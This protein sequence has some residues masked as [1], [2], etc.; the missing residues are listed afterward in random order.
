M[1]FQADPFCKLRVREY[2]PALREHFW[3]EARLPE[4]GGHASGAT[5]KRCRVPQRPKG[6]S[7][8]EAERTD[9]PAGSRMVVL[10]D[11]AE[12]DDNLRAPIEIPVECDVQLTMRLAPL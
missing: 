11:L 4:K 3:Q 10:S 8:R 5:R 2:S 9:D 1:A 6:A 7:T 12:A